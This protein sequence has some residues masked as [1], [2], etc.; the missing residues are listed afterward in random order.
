MKTNNTYLKQIITEIS[1]KTLI[2]RVDENLRWLMK[3]QAEEK[4]EKDDARDDAS[5][6]A[7]EEAAP[8]KTASPDGS[9]DTSEEVPEKKTPDDEPVDD[10][11][12]DSEANEDAAEEEKEKA[13]KAKADLEKAKAEK[14][15]AEKELETQ[16]Y[17]KLNTSSGLR[18]LLDKIVTPAFESNTIDALAGEMVEKLKIDDDKKY[19]KFSAE[20]GQYTSIPGVVNL[21]SSMKKMVATK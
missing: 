12:D 4:E 7:P 5:S 10:E 15:A 14:K 3:E 13:L 2:G 19:Q 1:K 17:I 21:L 16:S 6:E 11:V 20:M 8:K 9:V 18:F